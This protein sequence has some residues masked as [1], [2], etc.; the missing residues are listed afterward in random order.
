MNKA[1]VC[2]LSIQRFAFQFFIV[3]T[4]YNY[5][6]SLIFSN[7]N[8]SSGNSL[9]EI[10]CLSLF[11]LIV[12]L[13][14]Y[15]YFRWQVKLHLGLDLKFIDIINFGIFSF[16]R[17]INICNKKSAQQGDAPEPASPAR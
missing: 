12:I 1:T 6:Y 14:G 4:V 5:G 10:Q 2:I 8:F 11:L 3:L 7:Q 13:T 16:Y 15:Y 17:K 9:F